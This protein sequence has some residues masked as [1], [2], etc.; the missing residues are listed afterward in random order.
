MRT[1]HGKRKSRSQVSECQAGVRQNREHSL[2]HH[3]LPRNPISSDVGPFSSQP[4]PSWR[5]PSTRDS[6]KGKSRGS[7]VSPR[8]SSLSSVATWALHDLHR[9]FSR[10]SAAEFRNSNTVR[11]FSSAPGVDWG[12]RPCASLC[13]L[14][15]LLL[16]T[17]KGR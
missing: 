9:G 10:A 14:F 3:P 16:D 4:A 17:S 15:L 13:K 11:K 2:V 8:H 5:W 1:G 12:P 7:L 6:K